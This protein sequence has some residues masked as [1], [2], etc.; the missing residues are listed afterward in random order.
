MVELT[1]MK[2]S[3]HAL[4][5]GHAPFSQSWLRVHDLAHKLVGVREAKPASIARTSS[6][7]TSRDAGM[8]AYC[9][10]WVSSVSHVNGDETGV[11]SIARLRRRTSHENTRLDGVC[12]RSCGSTRCGVAAIFL[13][14]GVMPWR[15]FATARQIASHGRR[16]WIE[17]L[18]ERV[19]RV[20]GGRRHTSMS[21]GS[22]AG[23]MFLM[24]LMHWAAYLR[25]AVPAAGSG[26]LPRRA[27]AGVRPLRCG[28]SSASSTTTSRQRPVRSSSAARARAAA[29]FSHSRTTALGREPCFAA[30]PRTGHDKGGV[31]S[32]GKAIRWQSWCRFPSATRCPRSAPPFERLDG[33]A[34]IGKRDADGRSIAERLPTRSRRCCRCRRRR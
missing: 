12:S 30:R 15:Q 6:R 33:R 18:V 5:F 28:P 2:R 29:A 9:Q 21:P 11:L 8:S 24:R 3:R 25:V 32:R 14:D 20:S 26:V 13:L 34:L 31:E 7:R 17:P 19:W 10:T 1:R 22:A 16:P 23:A 4:S 27:R